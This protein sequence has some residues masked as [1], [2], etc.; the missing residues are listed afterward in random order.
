MTTGSLKFASLLIVIITGGGVAWQAQQGILKQSKPPLKTVEDDS[1][2]D[3]EDLDLTADLEEGTPTL[4]ESPEKESKSTGWNDDSDLSDIQLAAGPGKFERKSTPA[5]SVGSPIPARKAAA[6]SKTESKKKTPKDSLAKAKSDGN[7]VDPFDEESAA[8]GAQQPQLTP[9]PESEPI[10]DDED[11][12]QVAIK[13]SRTPSTDAADAET[14]DEQR[15]GDP[16]LMVGH[17]EIKRSKDKKPLRT[18][19]KELAADESLEPEAD[20][21]ADSAPPE[22]DADSQSDDASSGGIELPPN[23]DTDDGE[24]FPSLKFTDETKPSRPRR[25][26]AEPPKS[27]EEEFGAEPTELNDSPKLDLQNDDPMEASTDSPDAEETS[28]DRPTMPTEADPFADSDP[29]LADPSADAEKSAAPAEKSSPNEP[30]DENSPAPGR[31]S[32][33]KKRKDSAPTAGA[34]GL[35]PVPETSIP[36][37]NHRN[38]LDDPPEP[39]LDVPQTQNSPKRTFHDEE[40]AGEL[41]GDALPDASAPKGVQQPRLTIEKIA[42]KQAVLRQPL[43]YSVVVKNTGSADAH[44]VTVEDRIPKGTTLVGTAP[45][46][47]LFD[48]RLVWK[49]GTLRPDEHKKISIKVIPEQ[50]GHIGSV[51]RVNF[52]AEIAAET[53]V[54]APQLVLQIES[55]SQVRLGDK[56]HMNFKVRNAGGAEAQ[57]V[58]IRNLI[59][60]GLR[61][62]AGTDLE[63]AMGTLAAEETREIKLDLIATKN[64][65]VTNK[66]IITGDHGLKVEEETPIEVIGEQLLLTRTGKNKVYVDK[67]AVFTSTIANE[68]TAPASRVSVAEVIPAGFE[69]V[70]ASNRG[71]FDPATRAVTWTVGPIGPGEELKLSTQLMPKKTGDYRSTITVTGPAGS[72]ATVDAELK[73]EGHAAVG[74]DSK[75]DTRLISVGEKATVRVHCKNQGTALARNLILTAE[76]PPELKLVTGKGQ[77][78]WNH[79]GNTVTF[80]AIPALQPNETASFELQVEGVAEG[81]TVIEL[82]FSADHLKR[83]LQRDET[84]RV[85]ASGE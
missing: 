5:K 44:H 59:P 19:P 48:K 80:D 81:D 28:P 60:D 73:V 74:I 36:A 43:V 24:A 53:E 61:H 25:N 18:K 75:I 23:T 6:T 14:A 40:P 2:E 76:L 32:R 38:T 50:Q 3:A 42:P 85:A 82:K 15:A 39:R 21:F 55:P 65:K 66:T 46:A 49:L 12:Q 16:V 71:E 56:L 8:N 52:V 35:L 4:I 57:N 11:E 77:T 68:G 78:A 72:V 64:G 29:N 79:E 1:S 26:A 41:E 13:E 27:D 31:S 70:S 22:L 30:L 7:S 51:A 33:T 45:Q 63:Y 83:P 9:I 84:I 20:P 58:V 69:F 62:P 10:E 47:E 54:T 17:N 34:P 67:S 37:D